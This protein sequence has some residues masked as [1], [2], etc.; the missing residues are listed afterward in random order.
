MEASPLHCT[1]SR[2]MNS[3]E[4]VHAISQSMLGALG[5]K[6]GYRT[7]HDIQKEVTQSSATHEASK[8]NPQYVKRVLLRACVPN[9][10]RNHALFSKGFGLHSQVERIM[11]QIICVAPT[12]MGGLPPRS[13]I[14]KTV[15]EWKLLV[16]DDPR[17]AK[18]TKSHTI[19]ACSQMA[20]PRG[21]DCPV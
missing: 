14:P 10:R 11:P 2:M 19:P 20:S 15:V 18:V 8:S 1:T 7:Q 12:P 21:I 5:F 6:T 4:V 3:H 9:M 16:A 17:D 13:K